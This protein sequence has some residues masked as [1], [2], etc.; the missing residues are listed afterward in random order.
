MFDYLD[1]FDINNIEHRNLKKNTK[2]NLNTV[3]IINLL[4]IPLPV[5]F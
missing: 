3:F 2:T 1:I 4:V 5:C